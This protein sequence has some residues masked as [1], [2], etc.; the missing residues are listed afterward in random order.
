MHMLLLCVVIYTYFE[1]LLKS[2]KEVCFDLSNLYKSLDTYAFWNV[3]ILLLM[4]SNKLGQR[5]LW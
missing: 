1:D 3:R 5:G 2:T 4:A